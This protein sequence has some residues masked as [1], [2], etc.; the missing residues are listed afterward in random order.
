MAP[1]S[2][3]FFCMTA[4][5][6]VGDVVWQ[7]K[8]PTEPGGCCGRW[9]GSFSCGVLQLEVSLA[10]TC[11]IAIRDDPFCVFKF[12]PTFSCVCLWVNTGDGDGHH[13][14][15]EG[16]LAVIAPICEYESHFFSFPAFPDWHIKLRLVRREK[17]GQRGLVVHLVT[18]LLKN[19]FVRL[20][21]F[22]IM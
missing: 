2:G 18:P 22:F 16:F 14:S 17:G 3:C 19:E 4:L 20:P 7:M 21:H 13:T 9:S 10:L 12:L 6:L 8:P 11:A 1:H 15:K 5:V